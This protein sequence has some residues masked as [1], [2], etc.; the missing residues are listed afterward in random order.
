MQPWQAVDTQ[1]PLAGPAGFALRRAM[2]L[3]AGLASA[4][5]I[6]AASK[7]P[8]PADTWIKDRRVSFMEKP[9]R[10]KSRQPRR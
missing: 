9:P 1:S 4:N 2:A 3:V 6:P 5:G 7:P 8:D 10:A